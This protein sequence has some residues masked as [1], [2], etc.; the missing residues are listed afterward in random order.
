MDIC[1]AFIHPE[2]RKKEGVGE[3]AT[4]YMAKINYIAPAA[5]GWGLQ[6]LP[7]WIIFILGLA[8]LCVRFADSLIE[9]TCLCC[10]GSPLTCVYCYS[11]LLLASLISGQSEHGISETD[12]ICQE[13]PLSSH[14]SKW[15][16]T[17]PLDGRVFSRISVD[18]EPFV[19]SGWVGGEQATIILP[20]SSVMVKLIL[21][22]FKY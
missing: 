19:R 8:T 21:K 22:Y 15:N 12:K 14:L 16:A 7:E 3:E 20:G 4:C 11:L 5:C 6:S 10:P 9:V 18:A 2:R 1:Q 17:L 13:L